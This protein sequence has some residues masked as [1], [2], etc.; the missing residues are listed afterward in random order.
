[1]KTKRLNTAYIVCLANIKKFIDNDHHPDDIQ[2]DD[3][4]LIASISEE[5]TVFHEIVNDKAVN[6][7]TEH[8]QSILDSIVNDG[9]LEDRREYDIDDLRTA[10]DL[11]YYDAE[12]LFVMIQRKHNET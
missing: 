4:D 2:S 7:K 5:L 9:L 6:V 12:K 8:L 3:P 1:M 11:I 10:Y